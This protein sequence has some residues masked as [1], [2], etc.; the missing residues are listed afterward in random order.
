MKKAESVVV[1]IPEHDGPPWSRVGVIA[2]VGLVVGIAW[3]KLTGVKLGPNA[4]SESAAA[5]ATSAMRAPG[6]TREV[7]LAA[8]APLAPP[9]ASAK[10]GAPAPSAVASAPAATAGVS[11]TVGRGV[12]LSCKTTEGETLKTGCGASGFDLVAQ[13]RLRNLAQCTAAAH[14]SGKLSAL[15][16]LDYASGRMDMSVGKSST[17]KDTDAF[18]GCMRTEFTGVVLKG[19]PH[20]HTRYVVA[21]AVTFGAAAPGDAPSR[22]DEAAAPAAASGS[23]QVT[24]ETALVRDAPKSGAVVARLPR[25]TKVTTSASREG[26]FKITFAEGEGWVYRGAIGR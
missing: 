3:P 4:P 26:W 1:E 12:V 24:W 14:A 19:L 22:P 21:Y 25:G 7:A 15:F 5:P 8:T 16:T 17:V 18:L 9:G 23:A 20:A 13:P 6:A 11:A 2:A 10:P